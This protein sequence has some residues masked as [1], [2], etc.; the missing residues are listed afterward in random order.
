MSLI[1]FPNV[2][3]LFRPDP[4]YVMLDCDLSGADAQ[5]VAWEADD[6]ELKAAFRS[7]LEIHDYNMEQMDGKQDP[8]APGYKQKRNDF[9][10]A[11]HGTNYGAAARTIAVTLGWTIARAEDF[12][13]RWFR[14]HPQ[15]R[16]WHQRVEFDV[17]TSRR[18]RNRFGYDI[19]YFDRP[20]N[21]LPQ[22]LAWVP[23]STVAIVTSRAAINLRKYIPWAELLLQVHDS[24]VFQIPVHRW[25]PS[26]LATLRITME[27]SVPYPDPLTIPFGLA[28]SSKSWGDVKKYSWE[29]VEK[30]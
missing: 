4:G 7:G 8:Q 10:R 6:K 22:A 16:A 13:Q 21:L 5:V 27:V 18:V 29:G 11:V 1:H 2:R 25:N 30:P 17:Q 26:S 14:L 28:A 9:K 19:T 23:Q 20:D 24:L 15:I 12:Q 3:K